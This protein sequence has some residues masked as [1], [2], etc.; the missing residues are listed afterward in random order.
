VAQF[1][2]LGLSIVLVALAT[3]VWRARTDTAVNQW[4]AAQTLLLASW[5]LGVSG[6]QSGKHLDAWGGFTFASASLI[7]A[8]FLGFTKCYPT[9]TTWPSRRIL[10]LTFFVASVLAVLSLVT[11]LIVSQNNV[12]DAGL[13]RTSGPLYPAFVLYFFL[14]WTA[15]FG[16]FF[17]KWL[18]ARGLARA[19]LQYLGVG[20]VIAASGGIGTNL[21]VPILTGRSTYSWLG[22]Y[23]SFIFVA[24]VAHAI[25]RHRL[26]D[27][28]VVV[29]RGL[30]VLL[31]AALVSG[32]AIMT[33]R[34]T[35]GS[36]NDPDFTVRPDLFIV[37]IVTLI[38]FSS[39][40]QQLLRRLIDPYLYRGRV[41]Y[42]S[43]L[44]D[45]T[46]RIS[47]LMQPADLASEL[48]K[49]LGD[50]FVPE[51]FSMAARPPHGGP[52]EELSNSTPGIAHILSLATTVIDEARPGVLLVHP[53]RER[54]SKQSSLE[55]L[56]TAGVE[57]VVTLARRNHVLGAL[58]LGPR[59]SGD[60]YFAKDLAFI[61]ALAELASIALENALLYRQRIQM[62]E[63]SERLL[64]SLDS[65]VVAV[66]V[67]GTLTSFNTAARGLLGISSA[68]RDITIDALPSEVAWALALG[69]GG[70][71]RAHDVEVT[72]DHHGRGTVPVVLSIGVLRDQGRQIAGALA[73][74]TDLSAVKALERNQRRIEHFA[75]MARFYAGIAH[76][77]RSPLA[78]I[79]NFIAMLPDR[80]DD[81]EY[82]DTAARLLPMEVARIVRLADRL[83]LM[84][85]SEDGKLNVVNLSPLLNDI[86]AMHAPA[87]LE[88]KVQLTLDCP[89]SLPPI[90]GDPSQLVQLLVN[91]TRNAV[92]A[93]P[94]GGV[95]T[96]RAFEQQILG[97]VIV[98]V[99][100][101]GVG[102]DPE[103]RSKIFEPFFTTKPLGTGLGLS[104]CR[105][106]ADFHHAH[107]TL[108]SKSKGTIARVEFV[109]HDT[110]DSE[111]S[112]IS[113]FGH[114]PELSF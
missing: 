99:S 43:A 9:T 64:E 96:V 56:R 75:L 98:E 10:T 25:I 102:I 87:A 14:A 67:A 73:V 101:D 95:V 92:E 100:D 112:K 7:P 114:V 34:S 109:R 107:L 41:D 48:G 76:E 85:P 110:R 68:P 54:A 46:H 52:L 15:S 35:L 63:Y 61:E 65:A 66:D 17:R 90:L 33:A 81:Q 21:L 30:V 113:T 3:F 32:L 55:A 22:P 5:I 69:I 6:L 86:V 40:A 31:A 27:L 71:W 1:S 29:N 108:V 39:P 12:T 37:M 20:I 78:A 105:E 111:R 58:L 44:R 23:F 19:Q 47:H 62:L 8:A 97:T 103:A 83:R 70:D 11:P 26:L 36:W 80:F 82:R 45:A 38:M 51:S 28:R 104:I 59:R 106:I 4:F 72:I 13:V 60:A 24:L 42:A 50:A 88:S 18:R 89:Q 77:I 2:L 53:A 93:M 94:Y 57:L 79:S 49:I 16:V 91:L 74:V 84:A